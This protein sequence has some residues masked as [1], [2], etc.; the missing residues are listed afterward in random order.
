[1]L[2]KCVI[3]IP[4]CAL[5]GCKTA[6]PVRIVSPKVTGQV[7]NARTHEPVANVKVQRQTAAS[8]HR[9]MDPPKGGELMKQPP[10][11]R[12]DADGNFTLAAERDLTVFRSATWFSVTLVFEHPRYERYVGKFT[13]GQ[14]TNSVSGDPLVRTGEIKL[15]PKTR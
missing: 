13:V 14:S 15:A 11:V 10:V 8:S 3:L 5:L 6:S 12:T 2:A 7:V 9:L 1:M 4:L